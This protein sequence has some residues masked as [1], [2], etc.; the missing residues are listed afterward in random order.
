MSKHVSSDYLKNWYLDFSVST[1][2]TT[3]GGPTDIRHLQ[4]FTLNVGCG[5]TWGTLEVVRL[6]A[7]IS[8][9]YAMAQIE[10]ARCINIELTGGQGLS[11]SGM[12]LSVRVDVMQAA[13]QRVAPL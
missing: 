9:G 8:P 12:V 10:C 1:I 6:I 13:Q 5:G 4:S 2:L 11:F 3:L 7:R